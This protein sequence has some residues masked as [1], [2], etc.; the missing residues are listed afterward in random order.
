MWLVIHICLW[1]ASNASISLA[2]ICLSVH[3]RSS[4]RFLLFVFVCLQSFFRWLRCSTDFRLSQRLGQ[5]RLSRDAKFGRIHVSSLQLVEIWYILLCPSRCSNGTVFWRCCPGVIWRWR[6]SYLGRLVGEINDCIWRRWNI[7]HRSESWI[8][9]C[10]I[11][12]VRP[13]I[14]GQ[15]QGRIQRR[16]EGISSVRCGDDFGDAK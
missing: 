12:S 5:G 10:S 11:L 15:V 2:S 1:P 6:Q 3:L 13:I 14:L 16:R 9:M 7:T 8:M 4:A